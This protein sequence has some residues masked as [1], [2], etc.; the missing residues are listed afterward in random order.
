VKRKFF[1]SILSIITIPLTAHLILFDLGG[2]LLTYSK[3]KIGQS[4]GIRQWMKYLLYDHVNP[5]SL[6]TM[7]FDILHKVR[8]YIPRNTSLSA[9]ACDDHGIALP[10]ILCE[11]QSGITSSQQLLQ[12]IHYTIDYLAARDYFISDCEKTIATS[13]I[14]RIFSPEIFVNQLSPLN[15]GL[16]LLAQ[17]ATAQ[18][19]DGTLKHT[20][21]ICSNFDPESFELL[22]NSPFGE[23]IL[24]YVSR[25][26]IFI[27]GNYQ[28]HRGL[29]PNDSAFDAVIEATGFPDENI[30]FIDDQD[31]NLLS[32]RK[33][34]IKT[35]KF[36]G[37][38]SLK[39]VR[40]QLKNM[41]V[42]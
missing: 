22:I 26:N 39:G 29:K 8:H 1:L 28:S 11:L 27:S 14:N 12:E 3:R 17:C 4:A 35:I 36:T 18:N 31:E 33:R 9:I 7:I 2:V 42:L 20:V 21:G 15:A 40:T 23:M 16:R 25:E 41:G 32:A 30:I 24:K 34:G 6:R 38:R 5:L 37:R 19:A 10:L 13:I